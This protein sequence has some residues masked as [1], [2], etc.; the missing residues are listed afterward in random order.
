MQDSKFS[1]QRIALTLKLVDDGFGIG[2]V[3]RKADVSQ[4]G[5]C[6]WREKHGGHM[7]TNLHAVS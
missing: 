7:G 3:C 5:Y 2:K 1:K 4:E 6:R